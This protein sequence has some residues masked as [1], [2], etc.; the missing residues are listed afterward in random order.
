MSVWQIVALSYHMS[1]PQGLGVYHRLSSVAYPHSNC[2]VLIGIKTVL[3]KNSSPTRQTWQS[4][5]YCPT[6]HHTPILEYPSSCHKA[7][8]CP[9][10]IWQTYQGPHLPILPSHYI[11]H[12]SWSDTLAA[13]EEALRKKAHE[14]SWAV[15]VHTRRL[16][17]PAVGHHISFQNQLG[18]HPNK[19]DKTCHHWGPQFD[20][21]VVDVDGSGRIILCN[22]KFLRRYVPSKHYN[23]DTL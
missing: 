17:L 8:T 22:C 10:C 21:Y 4:T 16:R 11:P 13:R 6:M 3:S 14:R 20:Q 15:P 5:H 7:L 23:L 19:S 12:P 9:V 1:V 2:R 18:P